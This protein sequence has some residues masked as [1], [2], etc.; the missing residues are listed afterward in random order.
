[1]STSEII[2]NSRI[3]FEKPHV[4]KIS[5]QYGGGIVNKNILEWSKLKN[6]IRN[7]IKGPVGFTTIFHEPDDINNNNGATMLRWV[8]LK[9]VFYV[10]FGEDIDAMQFALAYDS[11]ELKMWSSDL[12]FDFFIPAVDK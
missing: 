5:F 11:Q 12:R 8:R 9:D 3:I 7:T 10:C 4:F 6:K 2:T 1:M